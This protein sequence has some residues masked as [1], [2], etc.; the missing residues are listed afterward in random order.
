MKFNSSF[1]IITFFLSFIIS[2]FSCRSNTRVPGDIVY[3]YPQK[4]VYY[5]SLR[6]NYYYSLNGG[7]AWDSMYFAGGLAQRTALGPG[8]AIKRTGD[9]I[10]LKNA[11][12]RKTY[13]GLRLNVVNNY[14]IALSKADRIN[15][16]KAIVKAETQ[17]VVEEKEEPA[18]EKGLKKFFRKIFGKKKKP[19]EEQEQ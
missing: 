14:T 6:S 1:A 3:Y 8:I 15:R 2:V 5:D 7:V 17:P 11:L 9:S 10:W 16:L 13:N 4:N 19:A 18:P 12:H